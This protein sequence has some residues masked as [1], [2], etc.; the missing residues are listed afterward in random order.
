VPD[1]E[2]FLPRSA[3]ETRCPRRILIV[4]D[5]A[6]MRTAIRF[7]PLLRLHFFG[8]CGD[9]KR[10]EQ[11]TKRGLKLEAEIQTLGAK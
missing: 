9:F 3:D 4:H 10:F 7:I 5:Q 1:M 11:R 6:V 8:V 2:P